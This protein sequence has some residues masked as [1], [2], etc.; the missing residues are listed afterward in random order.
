QIIEM[1]QKRGYDA[2]DLQI[3]APMYRGAAGV[4]RLNDLSQAVYNPAAAN[5]QEIEFRGQV[6]RV[7]DKVLQLVNSPENN[8]FNGDIGRITAIENGSNKGKKNA[9]MTIDFDGNE[10]NYGRLE[11][12]QIRLAH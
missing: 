1:S 2:N 10:V 5:K 11:W 3:L 6:F 12:S 7:G 4:D 8:V 9:S